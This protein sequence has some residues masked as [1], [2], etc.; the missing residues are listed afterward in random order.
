MAGSAYIRTTARPFKGRCVLPGNVRLSCTTTR[1][2]PD[3][4]DLIY[5]N[6]DP[7]FEAL[8]LNTRIGLDIDFFGLIHGALLSKRSEG[9]SIA[10]E[11]AYR[12]LVANKLA[13]LHAAAMLVEDE[14]A[15][16]DRQTTRITLLNPDCIYRLTELDNVTYRAKIVMLSHKIATLRTARIQR[17]GT[18]LI[19][20][21]KPSYRATV[22]RSFETG[23]TVEFEAM[24][25]ELNERLTFV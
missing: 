12:D 18:R 8:L 17:P 14:K 4:I 10:P 22:L 25:E 23:F 1:V 21:Q 3:W 19:L 6:K 20:G 13:E 15:N 24:L 2:Q 16:L 11:T 5:A 9:F 7:N